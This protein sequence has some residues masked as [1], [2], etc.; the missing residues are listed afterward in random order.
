[1]RAGWALEDPRRL[2]FVLACA[3]ASCAALV[4]LVASAPAAAAG[5]SPGFSA[6][7]SVGQVYVTGLSPKQRMTLAQQHRP[8]GRHAAGRRAG[9]PAVPQRQPGD[10]L[11]RAPGARR[12][13][14]RAAHGSL[15]APG[16]AEHQ[17]LRPVDQA[18]GLR[19]LTTRDGTKLAIDVHPPQ[20][21]TNAGGAT[22]PAAPSGPTPTLI[23]YSGYG[24]ADPAGPTERDRDPREPHGLHGRRREHARHRLLGRRVRLLRAAPEPRRLRRDRDDRPPAVGAAP[25]GRDDGHLLRRHQPALHRADSTRRSLAAI[26]PLS[27]H[28]RHADDPLSGRHPQ[29]GLRGELGEGAT[30][31]TPSRRRPTAGSPGPTSRSRTATRPAR[32]T[33]PST[34]RPPTCWRRS[35][36]TTTIGPRSPTRSRRSP[37][38]TRSTCPCSWPASGPT[39]RP[40]GTARR[41]PS[42]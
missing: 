30:S 13:E 39:S 32:P 14:V 7:G 41:W 22:V 29:H 6:H 3:A 28:R 25:Q 38:S 18:A 19:Y 11:P 40:A 21:V 34:A 2:R 12:P 4:L 33:R 8:G 1:M 36:R 31:T 26:S 20:D 42:T 35:A 17:G 24:Y 16:A 37:S 9:R 10:R 23:E 5:S 27:V 15:D